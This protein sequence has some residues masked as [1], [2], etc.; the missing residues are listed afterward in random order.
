MILITGASGFIGGHLAHALVADGIRPRLLVRT[1]SSLDR[2]LHKHCEVINGDLANDEAL[3]AA[4][5]GVTHVYHCAANVDT[6]GKAHDYEAVNVDGTK[7]LLLACA[8]FAPSLQRFVYMSSVDV[9]GF[10]IQPC[11]ETAPTPTTSFAYGNS[12]IRA[13]AMLRAIAAQHA[14]PYTILRPCNVIGPDSQFI[15]RMS[16]ALR[17]GVILNVNGGA[18]NGGFVYVNNL[19]TYMRWAV[20][21]PEAVGECFNVR[22]DYDASWAD[23]VQQMRHHLQCKGLVISLPW[24]LALT[25]SHLCVALWRVLRPGHE[26]LLHPLIVHILGRSCGHSSEKI[27]RLSGIRPQASFSQVM[28]ACLALSEPQR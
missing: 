1:F 6:W 18:A 21:A 25:A 3:A 19:I 22:D 27:R 26:P 16:D 11:E 9:Y 28:A 4:T 12:K 10:P 17:H 14:I 7:R 13:E 24:A 15:R 8:R 5:E 23:F 20:Q 2:E